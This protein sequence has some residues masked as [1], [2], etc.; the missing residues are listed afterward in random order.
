MEKKVDNDGDEALALTG[1]VI[2]AMTEKAQ[3]EAVSIDIKTLCSEGQRLMYTGV[4]NDDVIPLGK[5]AS[6]AAD[7]EQCL[8]AM[9]AFVSSTVRLALPMLPRPARLAVKGLLHA[10]PERTSSTI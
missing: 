6:H 10:L 4:G 8:G 7:C 3:I 5:I 2:V 1:R 9:L